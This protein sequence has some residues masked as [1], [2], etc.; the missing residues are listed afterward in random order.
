MFMSVCVRVCAIVLLT[1]HLTP[2]FG[3]FPSKWVENDSREKGKGIQ[4]G[5]F[6]NRVKLPL[7]LN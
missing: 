6:D 4:M 2:S 7:T 3:P 5:Q 1:S